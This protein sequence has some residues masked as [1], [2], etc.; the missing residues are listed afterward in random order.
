MRFFITLAL[1]LLICSNASANGAFVI[2]HGRQ[3]E[4]RGRAA[5]SSS[6]ASRPLPSPDKPP[7]GLSPWKKLK[8][9]FQRTD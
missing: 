6:T 8:W 2:I 7:A 1:L 3:L 9:Y 5:T 4:G